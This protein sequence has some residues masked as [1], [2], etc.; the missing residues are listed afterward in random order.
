MPINIFE[1]IIPAEQMHFD[2]ATASI[3]RSIRQHDLLNAWIRL[4]RRERAIPL[5]HQYQ[6]DHL[7]EEQPDLVTYEVRWDNG[8]CRF[9]I[10]HGGQNLSRV[11]GTGKGEG[12]FVDDL[13]G[14]ERYRYIF[15]VF[16]PAIEARRPVY[17]VSPVTD[18]S[19]VPVSYER[20]V[21]PFGAEGVQH[22]M[23]SLKAISIEG[24]FE[25]QDLMRVGVQGPSY[26][27]CAII[28]C[29]AAVTAPSPITVS[30]EVI[31]L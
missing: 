26:E 5:L 8:T 21:L 25:A 10:L 9:L 31:E 14:A 6:P 3:V 17:T 27:V 28:D 1:P 19:G 22:L 20:L 2:S 15:P 18:V 30:D 29:D 4:F 16:M 24:R 12:H 7:H 13:I 23:V 11:F